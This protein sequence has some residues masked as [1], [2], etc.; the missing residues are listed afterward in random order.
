MSKEPTYRVSDPQKMQALIETGYGKAEAM[1][2]AFQTHQW[3]QSL[4]DWEKDELLD[5]FLGKEFKAFLLGQTEAG[6]KEDQGTTAYELKNPTRNFSKAASWKSALLLADQ[7]RAQ[8][9][10]FADLFEPVPTPG[11]QPAADQAD[12]AHAKFCGWYLSHRPNKSQRQFGLIEIRW[13]SQKQAFELEGYTYSNDIH[14][15][16]REEVYWYSQEC[17]IARDSLVGFYA[18]KGDVDGRNTEGL[19]V[20]KFRDNVDGNVKSARGTTLDDRVVSLKDRLNVSNEE[21]PDSQFSMRLERIEL[22][23]IPLPEGRDQPL[24]MTE[25]LDRLWVIRHFHEHYPI[26]L[27]GK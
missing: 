3:R 26:D 4:E 10:T 1:R 23:A 17:V 22:D 24:D 8:N 16:T 14:R 25:N 21:L 9:L 15:A 13:S 5:F 19:A 6:Q 11:A 7:L 2:V 18:Y 27:T 12:S 20:L